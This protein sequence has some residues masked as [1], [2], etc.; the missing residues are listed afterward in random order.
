ML[1][2]KFLGGIYMKRNKC[3]MK[4]H[5][6]N[7]LVILLLLLSLPLIKIEEFVLAFIS[8]ISALFVR[9]KLFRCPNCNRGIPK[10]TVL[11]STSRC[12]YCLR[13]ISIENAVNHETIRRFTQ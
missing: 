8:V 1:N 3:L 11:S 12:P 7:W 9:W 10:H 5:A 6:I 4:L 13:L 2:L